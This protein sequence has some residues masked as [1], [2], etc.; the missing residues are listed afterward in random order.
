MA[1]ATA[2]GAKRDASHSLRYL[3]KP[4]ALLDAWAEKHRLD[5]YQIHR[6][7]RWMADLDALASSIGA[8]VE[9]QEISYAVTLTLGAIHRAPFVTQMDK[10]ALLIPNNVD[11]NKLASD[12]RLQTAE[13]RY[14]VLL[15]A[16][17]TEGP[18]LYRQKQDGLWIAS[19]IQLYL[20]LI[21][22]PGR[23]REQAKR[24]RQERLAF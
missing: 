11:L 18:L 4:G 5:S 22:S 23:G 20:D 10:I 6:Y 15:L 13:E 2:P 14:N 19:D 24:L 21:A 3:P 8:A 16:T 17:N 9:Q 7:Y 12:C 1:G